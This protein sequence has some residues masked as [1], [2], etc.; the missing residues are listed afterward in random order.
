MTGLHHNLTETVS[1]AAIDTACRVLRLPFEAGG[2]QVRPAQR[3]AALVE[4]GGTR[5]AGCLGPSAAVGSGQPTMGSS[6]R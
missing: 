2:S 5:R 6:A 4:S 1:V 3:G